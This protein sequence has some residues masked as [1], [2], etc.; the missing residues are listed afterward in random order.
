MA[1]IWLITGSAAVTV[2]LGTVLH[3]AAFSRAR[4]TGEAA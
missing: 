1:V 3:I 2:A 4:K